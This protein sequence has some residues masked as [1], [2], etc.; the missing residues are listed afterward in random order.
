MRLGIRESTLAY[1]LGGWAPAAYIA[2]ELPRQTLP[3]RC[4]RTNRYNANDPR[5][6]PRARGGIFRNA[7]ALGYQKKYFERAPWRIR[8]KIQ[9]GGREG[10]TPIGGIWALGYRGIYIG[11]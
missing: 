9:L 6:I 4:T 8:Q 7:L 2:R 10:Y 1:R 5:P 11:L 3:A